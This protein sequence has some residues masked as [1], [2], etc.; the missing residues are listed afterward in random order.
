MVAVSPAAIWRGASGGWAL[1][2]RGNTGEYWCRGDALGSRSRVALV[3]GEVRAQCAER[4]LALSRLMG[5]SESGFLFE[6]QCSIVVKYAGTNRC[7]DAISALFPTFAS[8]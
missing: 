1:T 7:S 8:N 2:I 4:P 6:S 3:I 5:R